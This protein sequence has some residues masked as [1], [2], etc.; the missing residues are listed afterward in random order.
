MWIIHV[1][2]SIYWLEREL[3]EFKRADKRRLWCYDCFGMSD[4]DVYA[5]LEIYKAKWWKFIP[6]DSCDNIKED[7]SCWWH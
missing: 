3:S 5:S 6:V 1:S 4:K 7:W 2:M